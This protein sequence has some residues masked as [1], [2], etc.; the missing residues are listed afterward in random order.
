MGASHQVPHQE[1]RCPRSHRDVRYM[2]IEINYRI[3]ASIEIHMRDEKT[4]MCDV[5]EQIRKDTRQKCNLGK[6]AANDDAKLGTRAIVRI[7]LE[8]KMKNSSI[9][10][11]IGIGNKFNQWRVI[12]VDVTGTRRPGI[13][14][15]SELS[16]FL[17]LIIKHLNRY[18]RIDL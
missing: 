7:S 13:S 10:S 18:Q 9:E 3:R 14:R 11:E 6:Q 15:D 5:R 1:E 12:Y 4:R 2:K 16:R 17:F 8:Q